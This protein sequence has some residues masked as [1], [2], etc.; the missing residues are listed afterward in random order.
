MS[1][2]RH[3]TSSAST[4]LTSRCVL[5]SQLAKLDSPLFFFKLLFSSCWSFAVGCCCCCCC[6]SLFALMN[7]CS[8]VPCVHFCGLVSL[9]NGGLFVKKVKIPR[10]GSAASIKKAIAKDDVIAKFNATSW[11]QK[12]TSSWRGA[13]VSSLSNV[14]ADRQEGDQGQAQRL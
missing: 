6:C 8:R 2:A 7:G 10:S 14:F 4:L 1:S 9:A 3:S 13:G 5:E 11:A 12:V